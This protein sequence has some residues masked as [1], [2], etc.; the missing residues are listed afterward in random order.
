MHRAGELTAEGTVRLTV[1][2]SEGPAET[3]EAAVGRG[4]TLPVPDCG[5]PIEE[6]TKSETEWVVE[7]LRRVAGRGLERG[8]AVRPGRPDRRRSGQPNGG[9]R[10][11][12]RSIRRM[13]YDGSGPVASAAG[14]PVALDRMIRC[15]PCGRARGPAPPGPL[16]ACSA[17]APGAGADALGRRRCALRLSGSVDVEIVNV[18]ECR[19]VSMQFRAARSIVVPAS[20]STPAMSRRSSA[21]HRVV[22]LH[23]RLE[24]RHLLDIASRS[25][26]RDPRGAAAAAMGPLRGTELR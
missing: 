7:D 25:S 12:G 18:V 5:R 1:Q 4:R 8:C 10:Y 6:A 9:D 15:R 24:T 23:R 26:C 16:R 13:K 2:P 22:R 3:W 11:Q 17:G 21:H 19:R 20:T 14:G